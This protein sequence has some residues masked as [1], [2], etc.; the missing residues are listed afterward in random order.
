MYTFKDVPDRTYTLVI[1]Q[2]FKM[3]LKARVGNALFSLTAQRLGLPC[4]S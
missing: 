4:S 3:I 2:I 1:K